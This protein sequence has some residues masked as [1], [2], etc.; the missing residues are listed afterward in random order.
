LQ[1]KSEG[2]ISR[3]ILRVEAIGQMHAENESGS[4]QVLVNT[5]S[6]KRKIERKFIAS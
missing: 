1:N 5:L 2:K 6:S 4:S 3:Q